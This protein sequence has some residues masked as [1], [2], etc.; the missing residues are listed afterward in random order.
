MF[1]KIPE[2]W[3]IFCDVCNFWSRNWLAYRS[4]HFDEIATIN[5]FSS[6]IL[7]NVAH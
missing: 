1:L 6:S 7:Y 3:H 4:L 5:A 2:N